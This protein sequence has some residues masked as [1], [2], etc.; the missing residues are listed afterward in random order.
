MKERI[1]A[2]WRGNIP[3]DIVFWRFAVI[4][5]LVLNAAT[6]LLF[7]TLLVN[8]AGLHWLIPAFL[9]PIPYNLLIIVAVWRSAGRY[10]GPRQWVDWSR[11]A[12]VLLMVVLTAS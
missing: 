8:D 9:L 7:M 1:E 3:L 5:G 4:Y 2:L 11:F 6:S 12:T 10:D